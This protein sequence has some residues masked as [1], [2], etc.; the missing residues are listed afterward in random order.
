VPPERQSAQRRRQAGVVAPEG[1]RE[2]P[3]DRPYLRRSRERLDP[4]VIAAD[5]VPEIRQAL[6]VREV[7]TCLDGEE[8][9]RRRLLDPARDGAL[10]RQAIEGVVHLDRV[11]SAGVERQPEPRRLSLVDRVFP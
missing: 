9:V 1:R 2:L 10:L 3:Q 5:A 4:L 6:D 7:A 11:E 8:K